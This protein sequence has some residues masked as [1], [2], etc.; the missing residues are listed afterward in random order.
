MQ[1]EKK[2]CHFRP[3]NYLE[4]MTIMYE[5]SWV[6]GLSACIPDQESVACSIPKWWRG[7]G[8]G[9]YCGTSEGASYTLT[10]HW[11]KIEEEGEKPKENKPNEKKG[12]TTWLG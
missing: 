1:R 10:I 2:A 4:D 5:K 7:E 12:R 9:P 6:L 11:Q 8:G 3:P